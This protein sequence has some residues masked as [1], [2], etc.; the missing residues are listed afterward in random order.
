MLMTGSF[1]P[2]LVRH[3]TNVLKVHVPSL[4]GAKHRDGPYVVTFARVLGA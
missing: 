4:G 1:L 3:R 2:P